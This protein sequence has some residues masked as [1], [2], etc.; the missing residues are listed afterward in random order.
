MLFA[1]FTESLQEI[2]AFLMNIQ[3]PVD[4]DGFP[5]RMF[6]S[7]AVFITKR[8]SETLVAAASLVLPGGKSRGIP[9]F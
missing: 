4:L 7:L 2:D 1:V 3:R 9:D 6:S 8:A 5:C